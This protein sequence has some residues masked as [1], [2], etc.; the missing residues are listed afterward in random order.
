MLVNH[1]RMMKGRRR[2]EEGACGERSE[3]N[4]EEDEKEGK[5]KNGRRSV[6]RESLE[7]QGRE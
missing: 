4:E 7:G 1:G 6:R 3:R 5:E 2:I